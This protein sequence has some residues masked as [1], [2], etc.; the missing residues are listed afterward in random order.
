MSLPGAG[1]LKVLGV[2]DFASR[3]GKPTAPSL[4]VFNVTGWWT[5]RQQIR[6]PVAD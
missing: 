4:R 5:I 3:K 2:D 6:Q 1:K